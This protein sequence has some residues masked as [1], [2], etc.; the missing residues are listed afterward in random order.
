MPDAPAEEQCPECEGTGWV[1]ADDGGAGTARRCECRKRALGRRL[2]EA[3]GIPA[4]Y[5]ACSLATF[6]TSHPDPRA[7]KQLGNA[8]RTAQR[9]VE[10]F[11]QESGRFLESGLLFVGPPG[12]G[13]THLAVAVLQALIRQ[14]GVRGRFIDFTTLIHQIQSTFDPDS[15]ES[16]RAVLDPVI[17]AD[18]LV[19]DELGAQKPTAWVRDI[20][21]LVINTR[22]TQ[23]RPTLFTTNFLVE[24]PAEEP[25]KKG[26]RTGGVP[27]PVGAPG[28][29]DRGPDAPD[30]R[31]RI[32]LLTERIPIQIV[33]RLF[34]MAQPVVLD[35]V[36]DH[37]QEVMMHQHR[38][39]V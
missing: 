9:Y 37:R 32:P 20:L 1:I 34:E 24:P 7:R 23:R 14:Y 17:Q 39:Q 12:T 3:A 27:G 5:G 30:P 26:A 19:L 22:Y 4:R 2:L 8:Q 13:K 16:K 21:Y 10:E 18:V 38:F 31:P 35:A 25:S 28:S 11:L 15:P 6:V 36:D 29:L 33:S